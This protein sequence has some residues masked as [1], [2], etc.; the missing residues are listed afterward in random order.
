MPITTMTS[1][2]SAPFS[3]ALSRLLQL[4]SP[5]LPVGAYSYSDGI[6]YLCHRGTIANAQNLIHWL[7][8]ELQTGFI[9]TETAIAL[10]AAQAWS[11][12]DLSNIIYWNNWLS[13]TRETE[14]IRLASW[15]MGQ[16]LIKLWEQL[17]SADAG[18][19]AQI[20]QLLPM[21]KDNAQGQGCNYAIAF[22]LVAA[23]FAIAPEQIAIGYIHSWVANLISA[24]VRSVPLGQTVGQQ[25]NFS[26]GNDVMRSAE[27]ALLLSANLTKKQ[28]YP[29]HQP[30]L[31]WCG[32]G[33]SIAS[34]NHEV[35]YSRLFRS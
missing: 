13:A 32:W 29:H 3:L 17:E 15:Q 26:L 14:E 27:A 12:N 6:E 16:S 22:G 30:Q 9:K 19:Q 28:D 5:A 4:T 8:G 25:V 34:A 21:A 1:V 23:S 33:V 20:M 18:R 24:A 2:I 31:E 7:R 35:Q 11:D 10:V